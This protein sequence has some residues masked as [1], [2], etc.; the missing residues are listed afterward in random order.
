MSFFENRRDI[1]KAC[2]GLIVAVDSNLIVGT[3]LTEVRGVIRGGQNEV[4]WTHA[5]ELVTS[6]T[7]ATRQFALPLSFSI[8]PREGRPE[9]P[10]KIEVEA[11]G[12]MGG[13]ESLLFTRRVVTQFSSERTLLVPMFLARRCLTDVCAMGQTCSESGCIAEEID[14]N[15][16]QKVETGQE[17]DVT[18]NRDTTPPVVTLN[19]KPAAY[20]KATVALFEFSC[21]DENCSYECALDGEAKRACRSPVGYTDL[22]EGSH[23]FSVQAFDDA[24]LGSVEL[25]EHRWTI[26]ITVPTTTITAAPDVLTSFSAARF[27]FACSEA[28]C[29]FACQLNNGP[30]EPC[31]SPKIF[32]G[33]S[34][35]PHGFSVRGFDAAFNFDAHYPFY[36]WTV[37]TV[38]PET[39]LVS[40]PSDGSQ[41]RA[42]SF[43]LACDEAPCR[44]ECRID[45]GSYESCTP[46]VHYD[47]LAV[48]AHTFSA[49]AIDPANNV[50][51]TPVEWTWTIRGE[52]SQVFTALG[53]NSCALASDG[54][55]WCWGT[56][57]YGQLGIGTATVATIPQQEINLEQDWAQVEAGNRHTCA[58]K[59][60]GS[61]WCWGKSASGRLGLGDETVR[62]NPA[63]V[64]GNNW[65][66]VSPGSA[67][68]CGIKTDGGLWCWGYNGYGQLGLSELRNHLTPTRVGTETDWR[69]V[70][71]G[72]FHT[73]ATKHDGTIHCWGR[74]HA[75]QLTAVPRGDQT[76]PARVGFDLDWKSVSAGAIHS[77]G[78]KNDDSL[79]CWGNN[80]RRQFGNTITS[81]ARPV[82]IDDMRAW[83]TVSAGNKYSCGITLNQMLWCWG[84]GSDSL[85]L[86]P[87]PDYS[88]TTSSVGTDRDWREVSVG[89][90][91]SCATKADGT[92]WCWGKNEH[93]GLGDGTQ[94]DRD[95]PTPVFTP[96]G[97]DTT[98]PVAGVEVGRTHTCATKTNGR[99]WCWGRNG[100]FQLGNG[101]VTST[102]VP[103]RV[104]TS[105]ETSWAQV[106][107]GA[108][109]SC[110]TKFDDTLWC[111]GVNADG[112]IG[113]GTTKARTRP[114]QVGTDQDWATLS[115][116]AS[117][118]CATKSD[119]RMWCWGKNRYGQ[120]GDGSR[121]NRSSVTQV[122]A[123]IDWH[124]VSA[125]VRHSCAIKTDGSLWCWGSNAN[126]QLGLGVP[127]WR[128]EMFEIRRPGSSN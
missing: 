20:T 51:A 5:F 36:V 95:V 17:N 94:T 71:A 87:N 10:V 15:D 75:G 97:W 25:A 108:S 3:E 60:D 74:N 96:P 77:C 55:L 1:E 28:D 11:I 40:A 70:D 18:K 64:S 83:G 99:L 82:L 63:R 85:G 91:I 126:G 29:S 59:T 57:D 58:I 26:D 89:D 6:S 9:L 47:G 93:G 13:E 33:L 34:D 8:I 30:A 49:R 127:N 38:A 110:A 62:S 7:T 54:S 67:H 102:S 103:Q 86:G 79:W 113:D 109:H 121:E 35:G 84:T 2:C 31:T 98:A 4:L 81:T 80:D 19:T 61:L 45:Q 90:A 100:E 128:W 69:Q 65:A 123:H 16:L 111:W 78:T 72:E 50:D 118:N 119:G 12:R 66:S 46:S 14:V 125:G 37:D 104:G 22:M 107:S 106:V 122:Q 23:S 115:S 116:F 124:R 105:T 68:S 88:V 120:L 52:W 117:H 43:E 101:S 27:E 48:G 53:N 56:N 39:I 32:S 112:Q 42:A 73:C 21:G 44:F 76:R 92:V 24:G 41:A 114:N